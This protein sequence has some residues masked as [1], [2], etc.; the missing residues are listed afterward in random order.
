MRPILPVLL[1]AGSQ[2]FAQDCT[3][4][5]R[6]LS[7]P[8]LESGSQCLPVDPGRVALVDESAIIAWLLG[9]ESITTNYYLD[10]F[11]ESYPGAVT[12]ESRGAM[13]D[14]GY[15]GEL[16]D[17][18]SIA[19]ARPDMIVSGD[20]WTDQ[21]PKLAEIAPL[22]VVG[23]DDRRF[24]WKDAQAFLATLLDAGARNADLMAA[25]DARRAA[26]VAAL[27]AAVS[28][29]PFAAWTAVE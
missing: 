27:P 15:L 29:N 14:I 25:Y 2:A 11:F 12:A 26:L 13:T 3:E 5:Q 23:Y 1:L 19:A 20:W 10:A 16:V 17:F 7:H 28:P 9:T 21:N 8:M 6:L 4:G 24:G 22:A 18:E